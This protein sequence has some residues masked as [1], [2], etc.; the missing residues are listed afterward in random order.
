MHVVSTEMPK[1]RVLENIR[2]HEMEITS[3]ALE[4]LAEVPGI[5]VYGTDQMQWRGGVNVYPFNFSK[6]LVD[7]ENSL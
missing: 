3:Y 5:K 4:K 1:F 2:G 6:V 7:C